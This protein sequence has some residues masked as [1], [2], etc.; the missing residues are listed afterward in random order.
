MCETHALLSKA[1]ECMV[2]SFKYITSK[3]SQYDCFKISWLSA[4]QSAIVLLPPTEPVPPPSPS[5]GDPRASPASLPPSHPRLLLLLQ[6]RD[7]CIP[8]QSIDKR[9]ELST[10]QRRKKHSIL[11][12]GDTN[13]RIQLKTSISIISGFDQIS[14]IVHSRLRRRGAH[15]YSIDFRLFKSILAS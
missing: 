15:Y 6:R 11:R 5:S 7:E 14:P 13:A 9:D 1:R 8:Y 12:I 10:K 4:M 3:S 2:A